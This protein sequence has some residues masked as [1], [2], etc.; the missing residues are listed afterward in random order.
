M[1]IKAGCPHKI[2]DR[3]DS[4]K[5]LFMNHVQVDL[6]E[7]TG[8]HIVNDREDGQRQSDITDDTTG[9]DGAGSAECDFE[10]LTIDQTAKIL[11]TTVE[12]VKL[13]VDN[14]ILCR[15]ETL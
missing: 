2:A 7:P 12:K 13:L 6:R 9:G 4:G 15:G 5:V 1:D 8:F 10:S 14:N 3:S 11:G